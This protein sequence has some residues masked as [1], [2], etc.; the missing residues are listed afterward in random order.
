MLKQKFRRGNLVY[1][2]DDLCN[3]IILGSYDNFFGTGDIFQ[4]TVMIQESGNK[5]A[6]YDDSQLVLVDEGGEYL[7]EQAIENRIKTEAKNILLNED[8]NQLS[9]EKIV[10]LLR[11]IGFDYSIGNNYFGIWEKILPLFDEIYKTKDPKLLKD[12]YPDYDIEGVWNIFH[13]ME[14]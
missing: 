13:L 6:W 11:F 3:A 1:I 10:T 5:C 14:T 12:V 8:L 9:Q 4:Y 7:I 2:K